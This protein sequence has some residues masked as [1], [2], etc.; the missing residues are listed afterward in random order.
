MKTVLALLFALTLTSLAG[1]SRITQNGKKAYSARDV[2]DGYAKNAL[3]METIE[4]KPF[5]VFGVVEKLD[6]GD[7]GKPYLLL[8]AGDQLGAVKCV[9]SE[10]DVAQLRTMLGKEV[11]VQGVLRGSTLGIAVMTECKFT[12]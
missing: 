3:A 10:S 1:G 2:V 5:C 8:G 6:R 7:D 4:G 11:L 9:F 12:K